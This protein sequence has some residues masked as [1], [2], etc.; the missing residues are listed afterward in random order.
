M[1]SGLVVQARVLLFIFMFFCGVYLI[2]LSY[3]PRKYTFK[4]SS[5]AKYGIFWDRE[6]SLFVIRLYYR[7]STFSERVLMERV[8]RTPN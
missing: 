7:F 6:S 4:K 8:Y 5:D 2:E 1:D 3:Y